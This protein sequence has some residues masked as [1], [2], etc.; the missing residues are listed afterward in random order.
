MGHLSDHREDRALGGLPHRPV[1]LVGGAGQ[2]RADQH[3]IDQLTGPARELLGGAAD[4]LREDDARVTAR[5][6]QGRARDR[7]DDLVATDLVDC[8]FAGGLDQAVELLQD[9]PQ[10]QHHVVA[11]VTVRDREDIQVVDLLAPVLERGEAGF[12]ERAKANDGRIGHRRRA[13]GWM[14]VS[15][16]GATEALPRLG[17]LAGLE[18][19]RAHIHAAGRPAVVDPHP[20]EVGIKTPIRG[21]HR[22]AAAMAERGALGADVTD[23]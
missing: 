10:R 11:R 16:T 2:R 18:A 23:L 22:V 3:R 20:L 14:L 8:A 1:R 12:D 6:E 4:Q 9:G 5:A 21:H 7:R 15:A 17:D 13:A 19:A